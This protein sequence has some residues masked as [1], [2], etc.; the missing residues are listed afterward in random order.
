MLPRLMQT[1][2]TIP[3]GR[4]VNPFSEDNDTIDSV[5]PTILGFVFNSF[6]QSLVF[7]VPVRQKC[8]L[9]QRSNVILLFTALIIPLNIAAYFDKVRCRLNLHC[10]ND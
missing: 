2:E 7:L 4:I 5:I 8:G 3:M 1:L 6:F 9:L 10:G